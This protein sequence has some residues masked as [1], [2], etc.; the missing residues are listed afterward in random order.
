MSG[1]TANTGFEK[2]GKKAHTGR[3]SRKFD[4]ITKDTFYG[5]KPAENAEIFVNTLQKTRAHHIKKVQDRELIIAGGSN[6]EAVRRGSFSESGE[7]NMAEDLF[8]GPK[9]K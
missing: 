4:L 3:A 7:E 1:G 9:E 8:S 5:E 6:P 2:G